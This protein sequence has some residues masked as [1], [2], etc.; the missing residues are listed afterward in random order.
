MVGDVMPTNSVIDLSH[1]NGTR[2]R[3]NKAKTDGIVGVIQKATQGEVYI[4]PTFKKNRTAVLEAELL[5]GAYHFGTGSADALS[6]PGPAAA[7]AL[8]HFVTLFQQALAL[9]IFAFLLLLDVGTFCIGHDDLQTPRE[10]I[11]RLPGSG[12][13]GTA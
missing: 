8:D 10:P 9:A 12:R 5:F 4:D 6:Y 1:H 7:L 3:F 11:E 13:A 2:L